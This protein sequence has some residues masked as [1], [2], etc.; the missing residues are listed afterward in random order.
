MCLYPS[1]SICQC[2]LASKSFLS[3]PLLLISIGKYCGGG[4]VGGKPECVWEKLPVA[5]MV[6]TGMTQMKVMTYTWIALTRTSLAWQLV[7]NVL[8]GNDIFRVKLLRLLL[9]FWSELVPLIRLWWRC[10]VAHWWL[11]V[12]GF[13]LIKADGCSNASLQ[14]HY[15]CRCNWKTLTGLG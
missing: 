9:F 12:L 15:Q 13:A 7:A 3:M 8:T 11:L 2:L 14:P 4:W 5:F 6:T 10:R 1:T